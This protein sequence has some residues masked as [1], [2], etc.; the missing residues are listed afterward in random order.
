MTCNMRQASRPH[1]FFQWLRLCLLRLGLEPSFH[2]PW[3]VSSLNWQCWEGRSCRLVVLGLW[4]LHCRLAFHQ[5]AHRD[6]SLQLLHLERI[7]AWPRPEVGPICLLLLLLVFLLD[8]WNLLFAPLDHLIAL[9]LHL[10]PILAPIT[11]QSHHQ[12]QQSHRKQYHLANVAHLGPLQWL[13][14]SS[15][16]GYLQSIRCQEWVQPPA[17]SLL[18][19]TISPTLLQLT[20]ISTFPP[21]PFVEPVSS[22]PLPVLLLVLAISIL[23]TMPKHLS[24]LAAAR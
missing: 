8:F 2:R 7:F 24:Y 23:Q 22:L 5:A 6:E 10:I 16:P 17:A 12:L 1:E 14:W 9:S 18:W 21:F 15:R 19:M 3:F 11:V 20:F 13:R 4:P